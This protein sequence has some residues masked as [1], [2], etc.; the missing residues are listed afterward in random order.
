MGNFL[1][2]DKSFLLDNASLGQIADHIGHLFAA[3]RLVVI[4]CE[5]KCETTIFLVSCARA[6]ATI[7]SHGHH[8]QQPWPPSPAATITSCDQP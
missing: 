2:D 8:R 5:G 7:A 3:R 4:G 1:H 6:M